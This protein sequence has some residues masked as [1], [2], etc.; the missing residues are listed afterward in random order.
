MTLKTSLYLDLLRFLAAMVVFLGHLSGKRFTEGLFW[1]LSQFMEAAV[2]LFFVL[3]GFVIAHVTYKRNLS[4]KQ[5]FIARAARIYSVAM[6]ALILTLILD[7]VGVNVAPEMYNSGW[8]YESNIDAASF[9]L[10]L[11]FL[12]QLWFLDIRMGSMLPYWTLGYEV[13]YYILYGAGFVQ[14]GMFRT[15]VFIFILIIIGPR[16]ASMFPLWA[17]GYLT[18]IVSSEIFLREKIPAMVLNSIYPLS[19]IACWL[20]FN[21]LHP[22]WHVSSEF[23]KWIGNP[24]LI[25]NYLLGLIFSMNILGFVLLPELPVIFL[26]KIKFSIRWF[27]GATFT[28]YLLHL[29]IAQF[30]LAVMPLKMVGL[31]RYEIIVPITFILLMLVAEFTERKKRMW[32]VFFNFFLSK[33]K[34]SKESSA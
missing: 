8:G 4:I 29:S 3:S 25:S 23:L 16:I 5:Y 11:F 26:N 6:P 17:L 30:L 20:Y 31:T 12:N 33:I 7:G 32:L 22:G 18:Y 21:D 15:G 1:Q 9:L 27:A 34:I 13:W 28:I 19:V 24:H 10:G 14:A 2:I